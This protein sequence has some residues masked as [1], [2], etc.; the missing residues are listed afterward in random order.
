MK[1]PQTKDDQQLSGSREDVSERIP[2]AARIEDIFEWIDGIPLSKATKNLA[3]DFS[4]AVLMAEILKFYYP[5]LVAKHNYVPGNSIQTKRDNW[6]TLNR[7][8]LMKIDMRLSAETIEHLAHSQPGVIDR[9]LV[10]FREKQMA[11]NAKNVEQQALTRGDNVV[12]AGKSPRSEHRESIELEKADTL[13]PR[14]TL[15]KAVSLQEEP[16]RRRWFFVRI[17]A[18]LLGAV[19]AILRFL[20]AILC[21]WRWFSSRDACDACQP[22]KKETRTIRTEEELEQDELANLRESYEQARND[23]NVKSDVIKTLCHKIAFLEGTMK[24]KDMKIATLTN[25]LDH[26]QLQGVSVMMDSPASGARHPNISN[27]VNAAL[28]KRTRM[29]L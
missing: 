3:R 19:L 14:A 29:Q 5:N 16:V 22:V 24:L 8:V 27:A 6:N 15:A 11:I 1:A 10:D 12:T 20:L 26:Q 2:E 13:T 28:K 9:L 7:K 23:L 25:H 17:G 21:F 18:A 4:D